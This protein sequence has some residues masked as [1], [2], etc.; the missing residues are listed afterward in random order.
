MDFTREPVIE[1]V[2]TPKEGH[3][4]V[5]RSSKGSSQEE[6]FV[7]SVEVVSFGTSYFYRSSEKPKS[8]FLPC[9]D[10]E[11]LEVRETRMTLKTVN[12]E[13]NIKIGG[14]RPAPKERER[15]R[16]APV[17][18]T[19]SHAEEEPRQE[20]KRERKRHMRKRRGRD[21]QETEKVEAPKPV[22]S[23]GDTESPAEPRQPASTIIRQL[24]S[25]PPLISETIGEY[26]EK[27]KGAFYEREEKE[28]AKT[29]EQPTTATPGEIPVTAPERPE[30]DLWNFRDE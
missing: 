23:L 5:V 11:I 19:T 28:A 21:E 18:E 9:I 15:E 3:K 4:L 7:D 17:E 14:G 10:Y 24:L 2:I 22:E 26:R 16:E 13:R 8:F 20:K 27:F 6:Y 12:T 29:E 25:P 1:T 30:G